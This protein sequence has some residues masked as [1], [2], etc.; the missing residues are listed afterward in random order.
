MSEKKF[1][2]L[3][4]VT[5]VWL[6][7]DLLTKQ[8]ALATLEDD[9]KHILGPLWLRLARNSGSAFGIASNYGVW[10][11]LLGFAILIAT[12]AIAR[13]F[14]S[15]AS[16]VLTG[17]IMGGAIGN[18]ADRLF[19]ADDGFLSG[20][21]VDFID[22]TWWPIFNFADMGIVVGLLGI[23]TMMI[24]HHSRSSAKEVEMEKAA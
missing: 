12:F 15:K 23:A 6:A 3:L 22:L 18:L 7:I 1:G 24:M 5:S 9:P 10:I 2:L 4:L 21:V 17:L 8:W 20:K 16:L 19:R 14:Q 13:Q 11:G